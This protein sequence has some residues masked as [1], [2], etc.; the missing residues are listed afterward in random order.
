MHLR[1]HKCKLLNLYNVLTSCMFSE[2]TIWYLASSPECLL[3]WRRL[4]RILWVSVLEWLL[5][6]F[7]GTGFHTSA[8]Y[9][10]W[11]SVIVSIVC[12]GKF[13]WG[14]F[15][16]YLFVNIIAYDCHM[17]SKI[18]D[19]ILRIFKCEWKS[20]SNCIYKVVNRDHFWGCGKG[21]LEME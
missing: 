7:I 19:F 13:P 12:K 20:C 16:L 21:A 2:L 3:P 18:G 4:S 1:I 8:F 9:W 11:F 17:F 6:V 10:F 5:D 15:E 14:K